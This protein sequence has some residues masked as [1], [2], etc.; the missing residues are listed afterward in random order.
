MDALALAGLVLGPGGLLGG[1][2]A[3]W[4]GRKKLKVDLATTLNASVLQWA[5]VLRA[6]LA[7]T[8]ARV[9]NLEQKIRVRDELAVRHMPWDWRVYQ[10]LLELGHPVEEPPPLLPAEQH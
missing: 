10:S 9:D 8:E 4:W 6:D 5:E 1:A 3:A 2:G 7:E